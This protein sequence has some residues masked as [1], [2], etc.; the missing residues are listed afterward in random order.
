MTTSSG[1]QPFREPGAVVLVV[2]EPGEARRLAAV[3]HAAGAGRTALA[4]SAR[5]APL[6]FAGVDADMAVCLAPQGGQG[7]EELVAAIRHVKPNAPLLLLIDFEDA[8]A[9]KAA[10][11]VPLST[12]LD[13]SAAPEALSQAF[14]QLAAFS[15]AK[16]KA[17]SRSQLGRL[18][19]QAFPL[20]AMLLDGE[21]RTAIL[22]NE[23]AGKLGFTEGAECRG[24]FFPEDLFAALVAGPECF[25]DQLR[26]FEPVAR[27]EVTAFE[28]SW[29]VALARVGAGLLLFFAT[30]V[31][32]RARDKD[33]LEALVAERTKALRA[34]NDEL[35]FVVKV[36][37]RIEEA[38]K[39]SERRVRMVVDGMPVM[40]LAHDDS[41][42]VIYWN[43]ECERITGYSAEQ[44][45]NADDAMELLFPEREGRFAFLGFQA[46]GEDY[47]DL[48]IPARAADGRRIIVSLT[49]ISTAC[50]IPGWDAWE[51]G[52]D[53]TAR[54]YMEREL[55]KARDAAEE[56]DRSKSRFL[57][58]MSHEIRSPLN[59][60]L[61]FTDMI[62]S[63]DLDADNQENLE[64]IRVSAQSLLHIINDILDFSKIE[65]GK[66]TLFSEE[67]DL[68][69]TV[70]SALKLFKLQAGETG[71]ELSSR[72]ASDVPEKLKGDP[73]RLRQL[74]INI[75]GNAVKYTRKGAVRL[76]VERFVPDGTHACWGGANDA[77]LIFTV[78]DTGIGIPEEMLPN[79]F[80]SF[81][82]VEGQLTRTI[83]GAGLGLAIAKRL[84]KLMGGDIWVESEE[85]KGSTF[86]FTVVFGPCEA[87]TPDAP[88]N[89]EDLH[90]L[91]WPLQALV[92]EDKEINRKLLQKLL[93]RM[94][95]GTDCAVDGVEALKMLVA[96]RYDCVL[97]D[98]QMPDLDG[99]EATRRIR[100]GLGGATPS[101]VPVIAVT[102]YAMK[103]DKERFLAVGMDDYLPKPIIKEELFQAIARAVR[104]R[105]K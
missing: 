66:L 97:M 53:V 2:G 1:K 101:D 28:R 70:E 69:P 59:G 76:T 77:C 42:K 60:I 58:D 105:G 72:I 32:D 27:R 55:K 103:G 10:A 41:G 29:D 46:S 78:T 63:Q 71:I 25:E 85:G 30:D 73:L 24:P 36:R 15:A 87:Q 83:Q 57:A 54:K 104:K 64:L 17:S 65:A 40:V 43:H 61:G 14:S 95:I 12:V 45:V 98:I 89:R 16:R 93:A 11:G 26:C 102:G 86:R 47:H 4:A 3:L 8:E 20:P 81:T 62:Q 90:S 94:E 23:T 96:N 13:A 31:T 56:A 34:K 80:D 39:L 22:V 75:V 19:L 6:A 84:T 33:V 74:L 44:I 49:N 18:M 99:L 51:T 68:D 37:K 7:L 100:A 48:E 21:K 52:E 91:L 5:D 92:V 79:I 67:F 88:E 50:P 38:L 35:T 9:L 82:R